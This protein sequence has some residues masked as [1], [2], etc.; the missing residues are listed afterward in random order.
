MDT[1]S[2]RVAAGSPP[3]SSGVVLVRST[4][5]EIGFS[6]PVVG[7]GNLA[8]YQ[9][10]D[11]GP[12]ALLGTADD[13]IVPVTVSYS[14]STATLSFPALAASVYRLTVRGVISDRAGNVLDSGGT[15]GG[16]WAEDLVVAPPGGG[17]FNFSSSFMGSGGTRPTAIAIADLNQDSHAD[18]VV[19]NWSSGTV[20]VLLGQGNGVFAPAVEYPTG[21]SAG[22]NGISQANSMAVSDF[23]ND[24]I[25]DIAV[26]NY[27]N[28]A[29]SFVGILLGKGDGSFAAPIRAYVDVPVSV[30][31]GDFNGDGKPDLAV[32]CYA[33]SNTIGILLR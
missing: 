28:Y 18:I 1:T 11:L 8:N 9:F 25:P 13:S 30:A 5:L 17:V 15:I 4:S 31:C 2:P 3:F 33:Y 32:S 16:D 20:G 12:D 6:E 7:G 27:T 22:P 19:A 24:G 21:P 29:N 26:V 23:N 14:G 10:Q